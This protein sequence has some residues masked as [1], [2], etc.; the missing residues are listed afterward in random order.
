MT[1]VLVDLLK[2]FLLEVFKAMISRRLRR[3]HWPFGTGRESKL[4]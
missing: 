4:N 2:G 3:L 1:L